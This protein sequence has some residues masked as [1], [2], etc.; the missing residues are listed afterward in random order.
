MLKQRHQADTTRKEI[1]AKFQKALTKKKVKC[2]K[3]KSKKQLNQKPKKLLEKNPNEEKIQKVYKE[4]EEE[5]R[6]R[7]L[8]FNELVVLRISKMLVVKELKGNIGTN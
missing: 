7:I 1:I 5:S 8:D 4:L 6:P 3:E 2:R